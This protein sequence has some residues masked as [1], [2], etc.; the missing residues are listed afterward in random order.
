MAIST[1]AYGT[2]TY[3]FPLLPEVPSPGDTS[4]NHLAML[5]VF[6]RDPTNGTSSCNTPAGWTLDKQ[7]VFSDDYGVGIA[8]FHKTGSLTAG[9]T[10]TVTFSGGVL[11]AVAWI[12]LWQCGASETFNTTNWSYAKDG[13]YGADYG[14]SYFF[15]G[16]PGTF[17]TAPGPGD[18]IINDVV[19]NAPGTIANP[20]GSPGGGY[21][22]PGIVHT[23]YG[24][25]QGS[26]PYGGAAATMYFQ[27]S[28]AAPPFGGCTV[29]FSSNWYFKGWNYV[30][31]L[32]VN[33]KTSNDARPVTDN[34]GT[35]GG[36]LTSA[37]TAAGTEAGTV[38]T[39]VLV[40]LPKQWAIAEVVCDDD[41]NLEWR[42][43]S[44]WLLG[45]TRPAFGGR[46]TSTAFFTDSAWTAIPINTE[47]YEQGGMAHSGSS[48]NLTLPEDGIYD[49]FMHVGIQTSGCA[50]CY[51]FLGV[52]LNGAGMYMSHRYER[53]TIDQNHM[54]YMPFSFHAAKNDVVTFCIYTS[55]GASTVKNWNGGT[56]ETTT[57]FEIWWSRRG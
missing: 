38:N 49:G 46:S 51:D 41:L 24:N 15:G 27:I 22:S 54:L 48:A 5:T 42:D 39:G 45:Y 21:T 9:T 35:G 3:A 12:N 20:I 8:R 47:D 31:R 4:A 33:E 29:N 13:Y 28:T 25:F 36:G 18:I 19:I 52:R 56:E 53:P 43:A 1:R 6:W 2:P 11:A 10:V 7:Q 23:Q 30:T 26:G 57:K 14:Q 37:D 50:G 32:S 16:V 55:S 34:F 44:K 17:D 40:P